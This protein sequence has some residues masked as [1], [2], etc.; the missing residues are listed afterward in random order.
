MSTAGAGNEIAGLRAFLRSRC[1]SVK[2]AFSAIDTHDVGQV[3]SDDF[4]KGV[5]GL[6]YSED[7]SSIFGALDTRNTGLINLKSFVQGMGER[8]TDSSEGAGP[9][10]G[11]SAS[12]GG[13]GG[14]WKSARIARN[15]SDNVLTAKPGSIPRA[16]VKEA[17]S[18]TS[19]QQPMLSVGSVLRSSS[20]LRA[21]STDHGEIT[22]CNSPSMSRPHHM[23]AGADL[24]YSRMSRVEEQVAAEQRLR[25]ETE[26]RIT[27]QLQQL[28]GVSISE[29]LDV[30]RQQVVEERMQR[31]VDVTAIKASL[32]TMRL[33][34]PYQLEESIKA[35]VERSVESAK[36]SLEQT[37][38]V[39]RDKDVDAGPQEALQKLK[40]L[41][42]NMEA[43]FML[44]EAPDKEMSC[45]SPSRSPKSPGRQGLRL[46]RQVNTLQRNL[47]TLQ[48]QVDELGCKIQESAAANS[49]FDF[50]KVSSFVREK[51]DC[52]RIE[53]KT[54][55]DEERERASLRSQALAGALTEELESSVLKQ[56]IA[57]ARTEAR[58]SVGAELDKRM[59][60]I[61]LAASG[62]GSE[63]MQIAVE[64]LARD[65]EALRNLG[66]QQSFSGQDICDRLKILEDAQRGTTKLSGNVDQCL[67]V[68]EAAKQAVEQ[69]CIEKFAEPLQKDIKAHAEQ[70]EQVQRRMGC[71]E[72]SLQIK[73]Q[74][75]VNKLDSKC[76]EGLVPVLENLGSVLKERPR[77]T[78][79][80]SS[81][82]SVPSW[83]SPS[84]S[85]VSGHSDRASR[86]SDTA[87]REA[88]CE[89][90]IT[91]GM[92]MLL[93]ENLRLREAD[94]KHRE[95][96]LQHRERAVREARSTS[97]TKAPSVNAPLN[98]QGQRLA[99]R[100]S[101]STAGARPPMQAASPGMRTRTIGTPHHPPAAMQHTAPANSSGHVLPLGHRSRALSPPG[102]VTP[103]P[104]SAMRAS[105]P[106]LPSHR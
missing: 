64:K 26:Q 4:I 105:T 72:E 47:D 39:V 70:L 103:S 37:C 54:V 41:E 95:H 87:R 67:A 48:E 51:L 24:L 75:L 27:Q 63:N 52:L 43:R 19:Q 18:V 42:E 35:E 100:G 13:E 77:S 40:E 69:F 101:I 71:V 2:A 78:M 23:V 84:S 66:F 32:E 7:A 59:Q 104:A 22:P 73:L 8:L 102:M 38:S 34:R 94:L 55:L 56:V 83:C 60:D 68:G 49:A 9:L 33:S 17:S 106:G 74:A 93:Q 5:R 53:W 12:E 31:Q 10:F 98:P 14:T 61:H 82:P 80:E 65:I 44:L 81:A 11:R 89:K 29:Q 6:G 16:P 3:T 20:A 21:A 99:V 50:E 62:K 15:S 91:M 86:L 97:P 90:S 85:S 96:Q 92:D 79:Q 45:T 36:M 46:E 1:G 58:A 28:V 57:E 76:L 30:L 88:S 25:Y